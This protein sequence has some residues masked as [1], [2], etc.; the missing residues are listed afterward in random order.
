MA[1]QG[2]T[3]TSPSFREGD[4]IPRSHAH[5]GDDISPRLEWMHAPK[6]TRSFVLILEGTDAHPRPMAHW[7]LFNI[8]ASVSHLPER[9]LNIGVSGRNDFQKDGYTGPF[10]PSNHGDHRY[11]FSLYA[12]DVDSLPLE[13]GA[14]RDEIER[15]MQGHILDLTTLMGRYK[16]GATSKHSTH[17]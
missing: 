4:F 13:K 12:L 9:A 15:A 11:A 3:L 2:F 5:D 14:R 17:A 8:P 10:P 16:R 7:L 1:E 6:G